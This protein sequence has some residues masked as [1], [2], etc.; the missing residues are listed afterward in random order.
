MEQE[1]MINTVVAYIREQNLSSRVKG[2]K[3]F[4]PSVLAVEL[5]DP[6]EGM[7]F[8]DSNRRALHLITGSDPSICPR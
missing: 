2:A 6:P 7:I 4:S 5:S 1:Q 8:F 3:I